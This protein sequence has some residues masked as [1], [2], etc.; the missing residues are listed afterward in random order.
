M[1]RKNVENGNFHY[2]AVEAILTQSIKPFKMNIVII[3]QL[4]K[5]LLKII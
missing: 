1:N 2:V 4:K 3:R 5:D